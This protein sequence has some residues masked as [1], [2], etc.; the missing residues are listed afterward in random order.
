MYKMCYITF[1]KSTLF[2]S[3][4]RHANIGWLQ[5]L[6]YHLRFNFLLEHIVLPPDFCIFLFYYTFA[7]VI[8]QQSFHLL[9]TKKI[10][11]KYKFAEV[12]DAVTRTPSEQH[13]QNR[14]PPN[15]QIV[16]QCPL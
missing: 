16:R 5:I 1:N 12:F 15:S 9:F 7:I 8:C 4:S 6:L 10:K 3:Y 14:F 13:C 11:M 2:Y